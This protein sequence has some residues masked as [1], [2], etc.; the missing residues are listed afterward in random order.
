MTQ[1]L[2]CRR[3]EM[4]RRDMGRYHHRA[5]RAACPHSRFVIATSAPITKTPTNC[6]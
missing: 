1:L 6:A 5:L 3:D 2:Q 4:V